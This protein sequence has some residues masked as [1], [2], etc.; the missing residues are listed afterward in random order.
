M[1]YCGNYSFFFLMEWEKYSRIFINFVSENCVISLKKNLNVSHDWGDIDKI[2][3]CFF[4][5]LCLKKSCV[6]NIYSYFLLIVIVF[7]V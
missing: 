4:F 2:S 6:V 5:Q 3:N 1:E 7:L